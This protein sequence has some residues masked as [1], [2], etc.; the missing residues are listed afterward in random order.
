MPSALRISTSR[1]TRPRAEISKTALGADGWIPWS[2]AEDPL[3]VIR[4]RRREGYEIVSLELTDASTPLAKH[5]PEKP[6]C[7]LLG[8]E[9]LG[10][11]EAYLRESDAIV[12]I[13]MLGKKSSLNV[14]VA[15]GIAL[16]HYRCNV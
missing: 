8:H 16:F 1:A 6:V 14:S 4:A 10:V 2:K 9:I 12:H 13:P 11:A 3:D 5:R 7:L 15:A